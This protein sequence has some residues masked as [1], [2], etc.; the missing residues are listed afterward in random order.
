MSYIH[1]PCNYGWERQSSILFEFDLIAIA[2]HM[3]DPL[4]VLRYQ[5]AARV[6]L[7]KVDMLLV[8]TALQH[9]TLQEVLEQEEL[10]PVATWPR[11]GNLGR[12]TN[13]VN[14]LDMCGIAVPSGL[15]RGAP[16]P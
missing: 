16:Q 1:K 3:S 11:N 14:L 9:Y 15:L 8:P 2:C 5:A 4:A 6:E 10:A 7:A 13:F 12:F